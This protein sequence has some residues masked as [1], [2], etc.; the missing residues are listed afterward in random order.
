MAASNTIRYVPPFF[1][2]SI[3]LIN[4]TIFLRCQLVWILTIVV[5]NNFIEKLKGS[6]H[7]QDTQEDLVLNL[8]Q[9]T[10]LEDFSLRVFSTIQSPL[11]LVQPV[12]ITGTSSRHF[13]LQSLGSSPT[14]SSE[15]VPVQYSPGHL[16]ETI[17]F[18]PFLSGTLQDTLLA[19]DRQATVSYE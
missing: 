1:E 15:L 2:I 5:R 18:S 10:Y 16:L 19:T 17:R 13:I 8:K 9:T 7:I 4:I 3:S 11:P 12:P 14:S 6:K